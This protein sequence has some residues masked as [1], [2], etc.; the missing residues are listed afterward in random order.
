MGSAIVGGAALAGSS[1][2]AVNRQSAAQ[3]LLR[4]QASKFL[5]WQAQAFLHMAATGSRDFSGSQVKPGGAVLASGGTMPRTGSSFANVRVNDPN[6]DNT[7]ID[8]TTQ[9]E[10]T[11]GVSGSHVAVGFNDSQQTGL[12]F[13]AATDLSGVAFSTDGGST[14]T[15]GGAIPNQPELVNVGDPWLASDRA[16]NM[17]YSTL[18]LDAVFPNLTIGV[19]KSTDGGKTWSPAAPIIRPTG[20]VFY[21]ADKDAITTGRDSVNS[22][23]DDL[24]A[25]WDDQVASPTSFF[26]GLPVAH[27][28]DGGATWH[29]T[30]AD[31]NAP[32][33]GCTFTQYIGA[34]PLVDRSN[35]TLYVAA[36]RIHVDD[37]NCVG[38]SPSFSEYI[39]RSTDGGKTFSHGVKIA[40]VTSAFPN[41]L[42]KLGAAQYMRD[43]EFPTLA[44][45]GGALYAAWNDGGLGESHIR[46][47]KSTDGGT[48]WSLSWVTRAPGDQVQPALSADSALHVLYYNRNA[49]NTLDALVSNS[50]DGA[51]WT[52]QRVTTT[53]FPGVDTVPQF[54]PILAFA[55][56]GDYIANVSDGSHQYYAWGDNRDIVTNAF[57]PQGRHDP[58]VF[59]AKG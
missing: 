22:G 40:D 4:L 46:L 33:P 55:Y 17:Y 34:Q 16:G 37:V 50:S 14:F 18:A 1:G 35:G 6:Q 3:R 58:N 45:F 31:R 54:D 51:T 25:A 2:R 48:T 13:T 56:M 11:I 9:S 28:T 52:T 8:Q 53:S 44:V 24:Y 32:G 38:N 42:M 41:G 27:S 23:Q 5:S 47:A 43:L 26:L 19:S 30:Y 15:D 36:E 57:W 49:N 7:Q 21:L 39:F 20:H 59:F 12:F 29:I 10:T